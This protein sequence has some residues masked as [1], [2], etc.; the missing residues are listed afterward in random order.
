MDAIKTELIRH[1]EALQDREMLEGLLAW[2]R[3]GGEANPVP[4]ASDLE[5]RI[6]FGRCQAKN[7]QT[8]PHAEAMKKLDAFTAE[9]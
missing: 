4:I 1:I 8:I 7:G 3:S 9:I 5:Q 2:I 6:A